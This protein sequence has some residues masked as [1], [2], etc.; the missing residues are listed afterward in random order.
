VLTY[1]NRKY[2]RIKRNN[3]ANVIG[4]GIFIMI[5][6]TR[7]DGKEIFLNI[8]NIQWIETLPDTTITILSGARI[9]VREKIEDILSKMDERIKHENSLQLKENEESNLNRHEI[10]SQMTENI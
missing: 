3:L 5:Q 8:A 9:I 10:Y 6:L 1:L 4:G 7:L 2:V